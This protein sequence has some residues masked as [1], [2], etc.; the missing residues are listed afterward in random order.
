MNKI[1]L[2]V[3]AHP[4]DAEFM[5]AGTLA[6]LQKRGWEVHIAT[7]T[8][9]D[10]GSAELP[11]EKTSAIRRKEAAKAAAILKGA[12]HCLECDDLF[13]LYDRQTILKAVELLR[14]VRPT[15]VFAPSP[16]DY[17]ADH[18][19]A[20][21]IVR[22]ACFGCGIPNIQTSSGKTEGIPWLYYCDPLEGKDLFGN[23]VKPSMIVDISTMMNAKE[24]MLG[25]HE[26]QRA[27]LMAHHGMDEYTESMIRFAR[28]RGKLGGCKY[29][30]GFRQHLGHGYPQDNILKT[31][32]NGLVH[33]IQEN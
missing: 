32:L 27:W 22:T 14:D 11:R 28:Q 25:C 26:S 2:S 8:A 29:A 5:C 30:E 15:V 7:M 17:M 3:L 1:V 9:G 13:V 23:G 19:I 31:E 16:Q 24:T 12:Y 6:L 10:C 18:E 20:S 4:D 21:R 33:E